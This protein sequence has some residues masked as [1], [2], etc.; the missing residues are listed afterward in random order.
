LI[1][2]QQLGER[3]A[4]ARKRAK[5]NQADVADAIGVARTTLVAIEKGERRPV[6]R[7]A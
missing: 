6:T 5:L 4:D 1:S 2:S 7:H 3:L